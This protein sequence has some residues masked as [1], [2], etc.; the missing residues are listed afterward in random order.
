MN[1]LDVSAPP[2]AA[3]RSRTLAF[4]I[5]AFLG[6]AVVL[7]AVVWQSF[8]HLPAHDVAA[9]QC[10]LPAEL[11][12]KGFCGRTA[13][14]HFDDVLAG[15]LYDDT[16]WYTSI[17][18]NGYSDK[19]VRAFK[20]G[21][22]S[23]VA[24]FP[25]HPLLA[26]QLNRVLD[27]PALAL[28]ITTFC[29]GLAVSVL[30]WIWCRGR[31][32][33]RERRIALFLM[34][35]YPYGW[36]LYGT[37][38]ADAVF[39]ASTIAAFV[40]LERD[41]PIGAGIAGIVATAARPTGIAVAVGLVAVVLERR[42]AL[43]GPAAITRAALREWPGAL[44][45][46]LRTARQRVRPKDAGVLLSLAGIVTWCTYLYRRTGDAFAFATVQAAWHQPSGPRTW[47]KINFFRQVWEV[48]G[49]S[50]RL[51]A[52]L[53]VAVVFVSLL[54]TVL[55]RFGVGY[56]VLSL[57]LIVIPL[58]GSGDFQGTGRYLMAAFPI[59]AAAATVV[60][61][62]DLMRKLVLGGSA[63]SLVVLT[64]LFATGTYLA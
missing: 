38:Y 13:T 4:P 23:S 3:A 56:A 2:L 19:Q 41:H 55:R 6:I 37:G 26:R 49:F 21:R 1:G 48:P 10:G 16:G 15:W 64:S 7:Y 24:F 63:V 31:L 12:A 35:L 5:F 60:T 33:E 22:Q 27:D 58:V 17:V 61:E 30:F 59:F 32:S 50:L 53:V 62:R 45:E 39:I 28:V 52:Q 8:Q 40:L 18:V 57:V 46:R 43:V 36:Y 42:G 34:L 9:E 14:K 25:S 20:E 44:R 47:L 29:A 51:V 54:P 11:V